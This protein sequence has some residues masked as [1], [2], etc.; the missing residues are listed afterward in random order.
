MIRRSVLLFLTATAGVIGVQSAAGAG[1][2]NFAM[3]P[4]SGPPGTVV[5]VSGTGC[6]PGLLLAPAQDF[7][8]VTV[9]TG[10]PVSARFAVSAGGSWSGTITVPADAAA[11]P[12]L[13]TAVC[14][15]DGLPSLLTIYLPKAFTVTAPAETTPSTSPVTNPAPPAPTSVPPPTTTT[16]AVTTSPPNGPRSTTTTAPSQP[17]RPPKNHHGHQPGGGTGNGTTPG[18]NGGG[19]SSRHDGSVPSTAGGGSAAGRAATASARHRRPAGS[20]ARAADLRSPTLASVL[21]SGSSP[22]GWLAWLLL[23]AALVGLGV[24][25]GWLWWRRRHD[26]D[27]DPSTP[28]TLPPATIG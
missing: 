28:S 23:A 1:I 2:T 3:S 5:S 19:T 17:T 10:T 12:A 21:E 16:P 14:V 11:L 18:S 13:V 27:T 9:S 4:T 8:A 26:D 24:A 20:G 7:V 6:A 25:G 15:S 22:L